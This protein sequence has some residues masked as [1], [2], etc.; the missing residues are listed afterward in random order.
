MKWI[1]VEERLPNI[2]TVV[3]VH[4]REQRYTSPLPLKHPSTCQD[5]LV[6]YPM[7]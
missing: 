2:G 1:S 7:L 6:K 4:Y 3:L 5:D